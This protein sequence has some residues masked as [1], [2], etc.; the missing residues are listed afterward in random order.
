MMKAPKDKKEAK[1][2]NDSQH[3][4]DK[5]IMGERVQFRLRN[6]LDENNG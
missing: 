3:T 4:E 2:M 5:Q 6:V 1:D